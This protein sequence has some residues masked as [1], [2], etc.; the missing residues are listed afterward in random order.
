MVG[1]ENY[2]LNANE[3]FVAFLTFKLIT[4]FIGSI[5]S[6]MKSQ[7]MTYLLRGSAHIYVLD[8]GS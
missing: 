4:S 7:S 6:E 5:T 1:H 2:I 3:V 8:F